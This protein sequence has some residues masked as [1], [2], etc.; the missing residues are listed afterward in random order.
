[1]VNKTNKIDTKKSKLNHFKNIKIY[2]NNFTKKFK[3]PSM[4]HNFTTKSECLAFS[5]L[6]TRKILQLHLSFVWCSV[7]TKYECLAFPKLKTSKKYQLLLTLAC[8]SV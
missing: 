7:W 8:Y 2:N 3:I 5:K 1:M 6:E 4:K